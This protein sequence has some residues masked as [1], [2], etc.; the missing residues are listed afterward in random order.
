MSLSPRSCWPAP[1]ANSLQTPY[2]QL[3]LEISKS[4][5]Y[6]TLPRK[7]QSSSSRLPNWSP[8][9]VPCRCQVSFTLLLSTNPLLPVPPRI[10]RIRLWN[11]VQEAKVFPAHPAEN[12]LVA[13]QASVSTILP[14]VTPQCEV[15]LEKKSWCIWA[16]ATR[17]PATES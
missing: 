5:R 9:Y 14:P 3:Q 16:G 17:K 15:L 2:C 13:H 6:E 12:V 7:Q 8:L 4:T 10:V 11:H 1:F